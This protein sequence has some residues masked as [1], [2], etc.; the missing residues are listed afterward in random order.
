VVN[1][2]STLFA[3]MYAI[4]TTIGRPIWAIGDRMLGIDRTATVRDQLHLDTGGPRRK[5]QE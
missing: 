5:G 1:V 2:T 3:M 4:Q